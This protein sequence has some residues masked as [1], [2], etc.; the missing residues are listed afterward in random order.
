MYFVENMQSSHSN[1]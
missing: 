1:S